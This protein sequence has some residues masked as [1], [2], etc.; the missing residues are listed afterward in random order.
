LQQYQ[1]YSTKISGVN[2]FF[3]GQNLLKSLAKFGQA[4][5]TLAMKQDDIYAYVLM[6]NDLK[7]LG[8][9]KAAAHAHHGSSKMTWQ[10]RRHG[11]RAQKVAFNLWENQAEG[12][13]VCIVLSTDEETMKWCVQ[14]IQKLKDQ[15]CSAGVWHDPTYPSTT[16]R[17]FC[18]MPVDV[19]GWALGSKNLL[20]PILGDLPLM[21]N[22]CW[23]G[24]DE[25]ASS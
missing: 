21:S 13:G 17:G 10:I 5:Y 25:Q 20:A 14:E 1:D 7:S 11:N 12:A 16:A 4:C 9:G 2:T 8:A 19:C 15:G 6:R 23:N 3:L 22:L 24:S 18:L